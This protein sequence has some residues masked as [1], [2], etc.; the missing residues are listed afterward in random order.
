M[1]DNLR[2]WDLVKQPPP[3]VLKPIPAG[4]LKGFTDIHP[5]WRLKTLTEQFGP[6]GFGWRYTIDRKWLEP[7]A[8]D[9]VLAFVDISLYVKI[10]DVWS[11]AIPGHGSNKLTVKEKSGLHNNEECFKMATT[12]AFSVACKALGIGAD[13]YMGRWDG[14]QYTKP[15]EPVTDVQEIAIERWLEEC[16]TASNTTAANYAKWWAESKSKIKKECG[17]EG[18]I[19]VYQRF[20]TFHERLKKEAAE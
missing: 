15:Y 16:D 19:S 8:G 1:S 18:A 9:E 20:V 4:R 11:E 17:E 2:I 6:C 5:Q 13:V 7:G 10:D 3:S 14:F 12:D